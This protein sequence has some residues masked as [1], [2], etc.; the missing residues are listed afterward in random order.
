MHTPPSHEAAARGRRDSH[1]LS[2]CRSGGHRLRRRC[3]RAPWC[4][5]YPPIPP[6]TSRSPIH[7]RRRQNPNPSDRDAHPHDSGPKHRTPALARPA[8]CLPLTASPLLPHNLDRHRAPPVA[9]ATR[10]ARCLRLSGAATDGRTCRPRHRSDR[11]LRRAQGGQL[12]AR[13]VHHDL[14]SPL[15][16]SGRRRGSGRDPPRLHPARVVGPAGPHRPVERRHPTP[17]DVVT[18]AHRRLT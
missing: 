18:I 4:R 9:V 5:T 11:L 3:V 1:A 13:Y 12:S 2:V 8:P 7:L 6:P 14:L 10:S 17:S 16:T 15:P